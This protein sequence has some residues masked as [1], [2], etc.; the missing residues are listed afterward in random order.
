MAQP[1]RLWQGN[2]G[3]KHKKIFVRLGH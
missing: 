1:T 3:K 2:F